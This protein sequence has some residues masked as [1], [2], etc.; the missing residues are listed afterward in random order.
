MVFNALGKSVC[1][2][3]LSATLKYFSVLTPFFLVKI[4]GLLRKKIFI[5]GGNRNVKPPNPHLFAYFL[6]DFW[7]FL[8]FHLHEIS[9]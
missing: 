7:L 6:S 5:R 8:L 9:F 4:F 2:S 1:A 3:V